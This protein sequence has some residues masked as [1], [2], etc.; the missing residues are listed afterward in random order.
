MLLLFS[1]QRVFILCHYNKYTITGR[2]AHVRYV[3]SFTLQTV[4][5]NRRN[6]RQVQRL[7]RRH[8]RLLLL[9]WT[10]TLRLR[11][12]HRPQRRYRLRNRTSLCT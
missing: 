10:A 9:L 5:R 3:Y 12:R 11:R 4:P 7:M 6:P 2:R 8:L 1:H